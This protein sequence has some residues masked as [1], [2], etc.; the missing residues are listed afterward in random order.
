M[1]HA[2]LIISTTLMPF[3]CSLAIEVIT[4]TELKQTKG[5]GHGKRHHDW[6]KIQR[7]HNQQWSRWQP[8]L[9]YENIRPD[10]R[11]C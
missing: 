5:D 6:E 3:A 7:L 11:H 8:S 2:E 4:T 1:Q 9:P 10:H